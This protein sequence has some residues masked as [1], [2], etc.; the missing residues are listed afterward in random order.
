[1]K[2]KG[3]VIFVIALILISCTTTT[4]IAPTV[5]SESATSITSNSSILHGRVNP[6]ELATLY[7]FEYGIY[8][9]SDY[10]FSTEKESAGSGSEEIDVMSIISSLSPSTTYQYRLVAENSVGISYGEALTF[11]T[12]AV[13][14]TV[15]TQS[16]THVTTSTAQLNGT[17][18]PNG[19]STTYCFMWGMTTNYGNITTNTSVGSG[20]DTVSVN[21]SLTELT[22]G[23]TYHYIIVATNSSGTNYGSDISFT[24]PIF[25]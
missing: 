17:V 19:L 16:A 9:I 1:M 4:K 23:V 18:N 2:R 13:P 10:S 24:T 7:H 8:G 6:N 12:V 15:T 3:I 14:P 21:F 20:I 25:H 22:S 5:V 11:T